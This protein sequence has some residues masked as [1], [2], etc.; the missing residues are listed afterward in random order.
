MPLVSG[1]G[2]NWITYH[3]DAEATGVAAGTSLLPS[4]RAWTSPVLDGQLYGEPLVANGRVVAATENDTV[5]VMAANSEGTSCG[6]GIWGTPFHR[7][8][9]LAAISRPRSALPAPR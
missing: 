7:V 9:C 4:R 8:T 1:F 5:Y 6:H 3:G 2:A